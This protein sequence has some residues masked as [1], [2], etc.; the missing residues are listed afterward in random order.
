MENFLVGGIKCHYSMFMTYLA[1][2]IRVEDVGQARE[3]VSQAA[4]AGA[5]MIE[6]RLDYLKE[7]TLEAVDQIVS[8]TSKLQLPMIATC[9]PDWEGGQFTGEEALRESIIRQA[10]KAGVDYVDIEFAGF[11]R[12]DSSVRELLTTV[13]QQVI[14]SHHN[15]ARLPDDIEFRLEAINWGRP[16][17]GKIAYQAENILDSFAALDLLRAEKDAQ[18]LAIALAMGSAGIVS[19]LLAKKLGA[20]LSFAGLEE[21]VETAAGQVSIREMTDV[22]RWDVIDAATAVYGVI[23]Y[24][25]G[26][27]MSPAVHNKAFN[28]IGFNGLYLP[29]EVAGEYGIFRD[30]L[31]GM[32]ERK[33]LDFKGVSV[34]IPHKVNALNYVLEHGGYLEPLARKLKAVN[35]LVFD[36]EGKVAG[37]N[38]DYAGALD[39]ITSAIGEERIDLKGVT[40]AVIG[41]GGVARA[42]VGG[43]CDVG[44]KV[45]I[46]NRTV[47]KAQGLAEEFGCKH[48]SINELGSIEAKLVVNATS[49]GMHPNSDESVLA[50]EQIRPGMI[51]MDTVYNPMETKLLRLAR[52]A[53]AEVVDG[54]SMFINQ[55]AGQFELFTEMPAPKEVMRKIVERY[56]S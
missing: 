33:W 10:L 11:K 29:L 54:V 20:F 37:Y 30:F 15:F 34:T 17:V 14:V 1:V 6:L 46:Y 12:S 36:E 41:A 39:A 49:I 2:P 52:Q 8:D 21:G 31:D 19:R 40:A 4:R 48:T 26:H 28:S 5:E 22:Y 32:I 42:L 51:V 24:P 35:T 7:P 9:R 47:E 13:P 27:S 3:A 53:G 25:V 45:T 56:L 55:A 38:T 16:V 18:R 43:L 50:A 44:A 23:G